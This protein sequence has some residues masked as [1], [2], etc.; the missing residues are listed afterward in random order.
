MTVE[1]HTLVAVDSDP[2]ACQTYRAN[3]PGVDVRCMSVADAIRGLP[4]ADVL[5]G[6]PPC[7]SFSTAGTGRGEED[8]RN[9]WPDMIEAVRRVRPRMFLAENVPGMMTT[10]HLAYTQSVHRELEGIGYDVDARVLDA[11]DFGVPQFRKRLWWWEIRRDL[12]RDVIPGREWPRCTHV[13]PPIRN[14]LFGEP[15]Q[16]PAV[17]VGQALGIHCDSNPTGQLVGKLTLEAHGFNAGGDADCDSPSPT[18]RS[19]S[20]P[21]CSDILVHEYRWSDK[22]RSKAGAT[23]L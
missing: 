19:G 14:G 6:G 21:G 15:M 1:W 13:W 22:M 9:A 16:L 2:W 10:R 5:L 23:K 7:Q 12:M 18:M 17:T 11:V 8:E 20:V 3:M 4:A